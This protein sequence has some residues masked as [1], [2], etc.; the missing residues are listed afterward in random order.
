MITE[1]VERRETAETV[2][3]HNKLRRDAADARYW[4][5]VWLLLMEVV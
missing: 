2:L 1:M 4:A 3:Y 5:Y